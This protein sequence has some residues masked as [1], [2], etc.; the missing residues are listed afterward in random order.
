[1]SMS[2]DTSPPIAIR[3]IVALY[4]LFFHATKKFW[5][6]KRD[7]HINFKI[8]SY[9]LYLHAFL[10]QIQI[11]CVEFIFMFNNYLQIFDATLPKFCS[12]KSEI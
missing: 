12:L 8:L 10:L 11:K 3:P 4:S 1:M 6:A 7:L 9:I 2:C 5:D